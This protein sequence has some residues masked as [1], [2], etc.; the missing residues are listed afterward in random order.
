MSYIGTGQWQPG[1]YG[2]PGT[3][4]LPF[5]VPG[6]GSPKIPKGAKPPTTPYG[7]FPTSAK[8]GDVLNVTGDFSGLHQGQAVVRFAGVAAQAIAIMGPFGGSV[9]VPKG[10]ETGACQIE[11]NGRVVFGTNCVISRG[12][13]GGPLPAQAPEHAAVRAWKNFGTGSPLGQMKV[14]KVATLVPGGVTKPSFLQR[15]G[16]AIALGAVAIAVVGGG[17]YLSR[18]RRK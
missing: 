17:I 14:M 5:G 1:V 12:L 11:L 9:V 3:P 15:H 13:S 2:L 4:D 18:R 10:A 6:P 16:T 8:W 7:L